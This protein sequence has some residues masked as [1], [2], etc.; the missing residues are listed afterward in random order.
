M[1]PIPPGNRSTKDLPGTPIPPGNRSTKVSTDP[2]SF[3][4]P[5][6]EPA[7][8]ITNDSLAAESIRQGGGFSQNRGAEPMG[9]SSD[10]S[11]VNNTNIRSSIKLPPT[12][13]R[14]SVEERQT[15]SHKYPE[16][17]VGQGNFPGTHSDTSGYVG[18]S[19]AAKRE[20]GVKAGEYSAASGSGRCQNDA[21]Q[22]SS[23]SDFDD[24]KNA[25]FT[26][27]PGSSED[28]SR[29]AIRQF[30]RKNAA[31]AHSSSRHDEKD[32]SPET[33]IYDKL[34]SEQRA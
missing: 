3:Q 10:Q 13:V 9:V 26:E 30:Q 15:E 17:L 8:P 23:A 11:T 16:E 2:R 19:T 33:T 4:Q 25:S 27:E 21:G 12:S 28:P 24:A 34:K 6:Q 18:G 14:G 5:R 29:E 22:A 31:T 20:M 7:G 1:D 32:A